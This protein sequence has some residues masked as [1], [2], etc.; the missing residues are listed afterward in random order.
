MGCSIKKSGMFHKT[1]NGRFHKTME[2]II[3][4]IRLSPDGGGAN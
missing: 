1:I 2:L 3:D 4:I